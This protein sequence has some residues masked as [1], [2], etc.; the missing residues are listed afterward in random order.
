MLVNAVLV[1]VCSVLNS[2]LLLNGRTIFASAL[3]NFS[4]IRYEVK[5]PHTDTT[6]VRLS[7]RQ[8]LQRTSES[9]EISY[10]S[11]LQ[12]ICRVKTIFVKIGSVK[13][14]LVLY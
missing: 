7:S 5:E 13:I 9:D 8:Q 4:E 2:A 6:S 3:S 12:N 10:R 11:S 14:L 1:Y